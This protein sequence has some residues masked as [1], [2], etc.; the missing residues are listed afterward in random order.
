MLYSIIKFNLFTYDIELSVLC[1]P[2]VKNIV[3]AH[4][5]DLC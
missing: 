1:V 5:C 3:P 2:P 4:K